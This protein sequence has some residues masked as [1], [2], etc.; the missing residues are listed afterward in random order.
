MNFTTICLAGCDLLEHKNGPCWEN[1]NC[2]TSSGNATCVCDENFMIDPNNATA[3]IPED[4]CTSID[5]YTCDAVANSECI[6]LNGVGQCKCAQNF[7]LYNQS[8]GVWSALSDTDYFDNT[9]TNKKCVSGTPCIGNTDCDETENKECIVQSDT[10]GLPAS[11]C[12]CTDGWESSDNNTLTVLTNNAADLTCVDVNECESTELNT[13]VLPKVCDNKNGTFECICGDGYLANSTSHCVACDGPGA[14]LEQEICACGASNS[15]INTDGNLCICDTGYNSTTGESCDDIDEC[16]DESDNCNEVSEVCDNT[17]GSFVCNCAT[18]FTL[19]ETDSVCKRDCEDGFLL[20]SDNLQCVACAGPGA[21]LDSDACT[22]TAANSTINTDS[23]ACV[24]D[25]GYQTSQDGESCEDIDECTTNAHDCNPISETCAN[26]DGSFTC[27]C[28]TGF[29]LDTD[30]DICK[31]DCEDGSI[32]HSNNTAC[33][34]CS[35]PGAN[36]ESD[37]CACSDDNSALNSDGN[38]CECNSGYETSGDLCADIDECDVGT[39]NCTDISEVCN[40]N[41]GSYTCDCAIDFT[42]DTD[43]DICKKDCGNGTLLHSNNIEC[44]ACSGP[45]AVLDEND[46]CSCPAANSTLNTDVCE[47]DTGYEL[48]DDGSSCEDIDECAEGTD[49]CDDESQECLNNDGSFT[50]NCASGFTLDVSDD[51]CKKDCADGEL[52]HSNNTACVPC[53]GPGAVLTADVCS[54]TGD[55]HSGINDSGDGCVCG[56]HYKSNANNTE[57]I[58]ETCD[59]VDCSA[60]VDAECDVDSSTSFAMCK[61]SNGTAPYTR[62]SSDADWADSG[63]VFFTT[64]DSDLSAC[65]DATPCETDS[66]SDNQHCIA[67]ETDDKEPIAVCKCNDGYADENATE[68][69]ADNNTLVCADINECDDSST[70]DCLVDSQVCDNTIG[71][72]EC[73]CASGYLANEDTSTQG[74]NPCIECSGPGASAASGS[75]ACD[76][77][78]FS[79]IRKV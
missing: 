16:A 13:C 56:D 52:L 25:D 39:D 38:A 58:L 71:S 53:S 1:S 12:Q 11:F 23:D 76:S 28:A 45:G 64:V 44:V 21:S 2:D 10:T 57:C 54:C 78:M 24:C 27:D 33:V 72:Y 63:H 19:D 29:T 43:D 68:S 61:C 9:D 3:C 4:P 26:N 74:A 14:Y 48:S 34:E 62:N 20:H 59:D 65:F 46:A 77:N 7:E 40:N 6:N 55:L 47:C 22:C 35:G 69:P 60:I 41:N 49:D 32:R 79:E 17:D 15:T 5:P 66:C 37:L 70:N 67:G 30:D 18:N 31:I 51:T 50:C 36:L 73:S 8:S 75:C 42:L